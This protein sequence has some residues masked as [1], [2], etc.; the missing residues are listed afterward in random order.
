VH[1][2]IQRTANQVVLQDLQS[3]NGTFVNGARVDSVIV[4]KNGDVITFAG[5]RSASVA[6]EGPGA[7]PKTAV[8]AAGVPDGP[9]F[10]QEGK[11]R[12][13]W[14]PDELAAIEG[15]RAEAMQFAA[16]RNAPAAEKKAAPAPLPRRNEAAKEPAAAKPAPAAAAKPAQVVPAKPVPPAAATKPAAVAA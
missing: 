14:A 10:N 13:G 1:A 6:L 12:F 4:L 2:R 3:I 16:L 15:A 5:V 8:A 7:M 9:A 11:A